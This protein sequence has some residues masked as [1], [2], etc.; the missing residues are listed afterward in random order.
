[1]IQPN[2]SIR[3]LVEALY[4][5]IEQTRGMHTDIERGWYSALS[6]LERY[7]TNK[8][9]M[10]FTVERKVLISSETHFKNSFYYWLMKENQKT[11]YYIEMTPTPEAMGYANAISNFLLSICIIMKGVREPFRYQGFVDNSLSAFGINFEYLG[12]AG[13]KGLYEVY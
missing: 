9:I 10:K 2:E 6:S 1:M 5:G 13:G 8:K 12:V 4:S 11:F 3:Q 7:L